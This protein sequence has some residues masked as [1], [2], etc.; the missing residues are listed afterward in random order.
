MDSSWVPG[1]LVGQQEPQFKQ[2][3]EDL[4][5]WWPD[6]S[7]SGNMVRAIQNIY[8][9]RDCNNNG[10]FT[11]NSN[12]A[13]NR[14]LLLNSLPSNVTAEDG[15]SSGSLGTSPDT[16]YALSFCSGGD[17]PAQNLTASVNSTSMGLR[18]SCPYQKQGAAFEGDFCISRYSNSPTYEILNISIDMMVCDMMDLDMSWDSFNKTWWNHM[19]CL[20]MR[21][22]K[23]STRLKFATG[24]ASLPL[25]P[26]TIYPFLQCNLNLSESDCLRCLIHSISDYQN[27][28]R[29][30]SGRVVRWSSCYLRWDL[31]Y[32]YVYSRPLHHH[33]H[34]HHPHHHLLQVLL[35]AHFILFEFLFSSF[36][37]NSSKGR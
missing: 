7:C 26:H 27:W 13:E 25:T 3:F 17:L 6:F 5:L 37:K 14:R 21:A 23:G 36:R 16:V 20:T 22:S 11:A 30:N 18:E 29:D 33:L 2:S 31:Y 12:Y 28:C 1:A 15:F 4:P 24:E 9:Y 8:K 19:E 10:N 35:C 32:F 34:R